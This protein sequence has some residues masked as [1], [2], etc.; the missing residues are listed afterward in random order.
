ML[1]STETRAVLLSSTEANATEDS[2]FWPRGNALS[3][4]LGF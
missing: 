3:L 4:E 1:I 2:V